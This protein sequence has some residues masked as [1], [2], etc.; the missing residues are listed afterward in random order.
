MQSIANLQ[1]F[2]SKIQNLDRAYLLLYKKG[3]AVNDCAYNS[4]AEAEQR[5]KN[6][7]IF[8]ANVSEVKDIHPHYGVDSVPSFLEI[9]KGKVTQLIKGCNTENYYVS[10][11]EKSIFQTINSNE[12]PLHRVTVYST[13]TCSWC[14]T[15]KAYLKQHHIPFTD[16]DVS[17][18]QQAAQEM[19]RRSGQQGVPQTDINGTIVVGFDK[20][21]INTLLGIQ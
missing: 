6:T 2:L 4:I 14:H 21:K 1:D 18:N 11:I 19:V 16:I 3:S 5:V 13:P 15:L 17:R 10:A 9:Q 8:T 12:K 20:I 7:I